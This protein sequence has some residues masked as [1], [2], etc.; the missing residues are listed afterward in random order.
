MIPPRLARGLLRAMALERVLL[1]R[2]A[3]GR[4]LVA[5]KLRNPTARPAQPQAPTVRA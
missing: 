2:A 3:R 5:D 4:D 1:A